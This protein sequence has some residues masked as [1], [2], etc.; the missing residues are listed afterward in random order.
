MLSIYLHRPLL[1]LLALGF[2]SGVPF[3][4]TLSTLSF[5]L[6]E[7]HV[8]KSVIGLF[9][10]ASLPYSLK[11]LWSPFIDSFSVPYLTKTF[12]RRKSWSLLAQAGT[13]I[14]IIALGLSN[15]EKNLFLTGVFAFLVSFFA[16]TQDII[17][18]AYRIELLHEKST[19]AGAA[20]ETIGFRLGMLTSGAGTLYLAACLN[21]TLAYCLTAL[22]GI[23]GI[24]AVLMLKE[25][26]IKHEQ[27]IKEK[28]P[29]TF[30]NSFYQI[31]SNSWKDLL[32]KSYFPYLL[33]FIF[34][35][36][37]GDTVLNSMSTPFLYE[38]GFSKIEYANV[39]K[40]FGIS[41]MV[42]G[43]LIGGILVHQL[44]I[45]QTLVMCA[46]LQTLSCLMF[47]IQ[48]QAGHVLSILVITIA[49]E[50][51]CSGLC[52]TAFIAYLSKFCKAPFTA[53]QFT[54]LY[55]VGSL[56]RVLIS[57][58]SGWIADTY[59]WMILFFLSSLFSVP[60]LYLIVKIK[61]QQ[62]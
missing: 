36:K 42:S 50:S 58:G 51:F 32:K 22:T 61:R 6:T 9:M 2:V 60:I 14:S 41:M 49:V 54:L 16:A 20:M 52:S 57:T 38:L 12:S 26:S 56:S 4:L 45:I 59:G 55:S 10:L 18:D 44:G 39:T 43:G 37:M 8:S 25:P 23:L 5:W 46:T 27:K 19:G 62:R 17:T 7:L 35:F 40:F 48:A 28:P 15:P 53:S 29:T 1:I 21:W 3:L 30:I 24:I 13:F 34:C 33:L 47:M 31:Y 11:F